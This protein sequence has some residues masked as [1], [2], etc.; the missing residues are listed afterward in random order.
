[1]E[2]INDFGNVKVEIRLVSNN[3]DLIN[4]VLQERDINSEH[5]EVV[6]NALRYN[7]WTMEQFSMLTGL[8]YSTI[9]NMTRPDFVG[10]VIDTK[11]DFCY[12][13]SSIN[14]KGGKFIVRNEKSEKYLPKTDK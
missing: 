7:V 5:K 4:T 8:A 12:P 9:R 2:D 14:S 6:K 3:S 13:F 1:M 11:L 10:G